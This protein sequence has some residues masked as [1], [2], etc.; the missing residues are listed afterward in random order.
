MIKSIVI[1]A[2]LALSHVFV[3]TECD[4]KGDF[5]GHFEAVQVGA[6]LNDDLSG[7][8]RIDEDPEDLAEGDVI[9]FADGNYR[10]VGYL[11]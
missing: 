11:H 10:Y 3:V 4:H 1:G 5:T 7:V 2:F 6:F 9:V 8:V